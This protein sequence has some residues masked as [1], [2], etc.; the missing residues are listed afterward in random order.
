MSDKL[1]IR[2]CRFAYK[3]SAKWEDLQE[4]GDEFIRFCDDC[5]KEVYFCDSDDTL[6]SLVRLNRC[7]AILKP[8][9]REFLLGDIEYN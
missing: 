8:G 4:T 3:C 7:I 5:E 9:S 6:V 2:N 1:T